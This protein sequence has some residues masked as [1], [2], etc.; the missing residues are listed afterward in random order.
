MI[1]LMSIVNQQISI[2]ALPCARHFVYMANT[3]STAPDPM[4][5]IGKPKRLGKKT[6]NNRI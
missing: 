3:A 6:I 2:E 4:N 1:I 5:L